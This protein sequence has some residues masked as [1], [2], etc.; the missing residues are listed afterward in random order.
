MVVTGE[1]TWSASSHAELM[2]ESGAPFWWPFCTVGGHC[3][4]DFSTCRQ[5]CRSE[6]LMPALVADGLFCSLHIHSPALGHLGCFWAPCATLVFIT[7]FKLNSPSN[8][9][10][11]EIQLNGIICQGISA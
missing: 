8:Y 1:I 6:V 9:L 5:S 10:Q 4:P 2:G 11:A 3:M 7:A